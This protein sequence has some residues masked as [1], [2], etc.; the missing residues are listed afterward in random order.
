MYNVKIEYFKL[1]SKISHLYSD[2]KSPDKAQKRDLKELWRL[3]TI[4][5]Y[6][7]DGPVEVWYKLQLDWPATIT[8]KEFIRR[9]IEFLSK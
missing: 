8:E 1:F 5:Q 4:V 3:G 9:I 7:E 6:E 2:L